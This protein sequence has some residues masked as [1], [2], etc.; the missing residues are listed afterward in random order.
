[1]NQGCNCQKKKKHADSCNLWRT[2][3]GWSQNLLSWDPL[4]CPCHANSQWR[5]QP[6][7]DCTSPSGMYRSLRIEFVKALTTESFL[8][9]WY[10]CL[11]GGGTALPQ[12]TENTARRHKSSSLT[13]WLSAQMW[14]MF[15]W[16]H[17]QCVYFGYVFV[18]RLE[19][20]C[21]VSCTFHSFGTYINGDSL[22][23]SLGAP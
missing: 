20:W 22:A 12:R 3:V 4:P 15:R 2:C 18:G 16:S 1:M 9:G 21:N 7:G 17:V 6:A 13:H 19:W 10:Q 23:T 5:M 11:S 8:G 14:Q